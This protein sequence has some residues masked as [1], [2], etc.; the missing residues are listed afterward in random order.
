METTLTSES[1]PA[2]REAFWLRHYQLH[3]AS[4][5]PRA[6]YCRQNSLCYDNF[7]YWF[8][9][10][11]GLSPRNGSELIAIKTKP[12]AEFS[13]KTLCTLNLNDGR[14]LQVHDLTALALIIDKMR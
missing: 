1:S 6:E 8:K 13:A 12:I 10:W 7:G 5:L 2:E 11:S 14:Y 4:G 9:K 3:Q